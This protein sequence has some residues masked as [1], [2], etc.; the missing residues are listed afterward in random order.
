MKKG[1]IK[2]I[3]FDKDN[4][5]ISKKGISTVIVTLIVIVLSLVAIGIVWGVANNLIQEESEAVGQ[6]VEGLLLSLKIESAI[7][8]E[9][10]EVSVTVKRGVG[11]REVVGLNFIFYDGQNS[12]TIRE[13]VPFEE[14][15]LKKFTFTLLEI[16]PE[17]LEEV[18]VAPVYK[19]SSGEEFEGE[20]FNSFEIKSSP[21]GITGQ[22]VSNFEKLGFS[23]VGKMEYGPFSSDEPKLPEFRKAIVDPLDVLPGDNQTFTVEVYSPYGVLNVTSITELDNSTSKLNFEKINETT[24]EENETIETWEVTW[25]VND[26]HTTTYRTNITAEDNE[27]NSNSIILTWTDSCKSQIFHGQ[28]NTINSCTV[29]SG[30]EGLD[31]GS[32]TINSGETLTLSGGTFYFNSGQSITV[33]GSISLSGGSISKG[34]LSYTDTDGD[35]YAPSGTLKTSSS[36]AVRAKDALGTNDC[37]DSNANAKPGQTSWFTAH[38]GDTSYDYNCDSSATKRWTA[39]DAS[40]SSCFWNNVDSLCDIGL[41]GSIGWTSSTSPSCG[42]S[43]TYISATG[44]SGC[45]IG[46][47]SQGACSGDSP[48]C[49][50]SSTTQECR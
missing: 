30:V 40:C 32:L 37:Y 34:N 42:S 6:G 47:L 39:T 14:F 20:I 48:S 7:I 11:G 28:D 16:N 13:D 35:G 5:L 19:R 43:G 17:N 24:N 26:V 38:R 2:L 25:V 23:G 27:D 31:G 21:E 29:S 15:S 50:S 9:N 8:E 12:E 41:V 3:R 10:G 49:S 33:S 1:G 4:I 46:G 18:S 44:G 36:N 45:I 22:A